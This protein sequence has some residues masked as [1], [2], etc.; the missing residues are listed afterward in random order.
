MNKAK[1]LQTVATALL[2]SLGLTACGSGG[3]S[4]SSNNSAELKRLEGDLQAKQAEI[5]KL[6]E[7]LSNASNNPQRQDIEKKLKQAIEDSKQAEA[8]INRLNDKVTETTKDLGEKQ[9]EIADLNG[10]LSKADAEIAQ[11]EEVEKALNQVKS[12][13][14]TANEKIGEFVEAIKEANKVATTQQKKIDDYEEQIFALEGEVN[15]LTQNQ[16]EAS[17]KIEKLTT[18]ITELKSQQEKAKQAKQDAEAQIQRLDDEK[19]AAINEANLKQTKIDEFTLAL[20]EATAKASQAEKDKA[21]IENTL[22]T[23]HQEKLGL[24]RQVIDLSDQLNSTQIQVDDLTQQ[25]NDLR[26]QAVIN[27]TS[28]ETLKLK[29]IEAESLVSKNQQ[30]IERLAGE[31]KTASDE[32]N[33]LLEEKRQLEQRIETLQQKL[34][35][36]N[37]NHTELNAQLRIAS[38]KLKD[39]L[40]ELNKF[41]KVQFSKTQTKNI[42]IVLKS[43]YKDLSLDQSKRNSVYV[44]GKQVNTKLSLPNSPSISDDEDELELDEPVYIGYMYDDGQSGY[45]LHKPNNGNSAQ[46]V[47]GGIPTL[48]SSFKDIEQK[49]TAIYQG[50][51][52]QITADLAGN[53]VTNVQADLD[54]TYN[55]S[56]TVNFAEKSVTGKVGDVALKAEKIANTSQVRVEKNYIRFDGVATYEGTDPSLS[57]AMGTYEGIFTGTNANGIAGMTDVK[58]NTKL[59]SIGFAGKEVEPPSQ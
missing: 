22:N 57:G 46:V 18:Q 6:R 20:K 38:E 42:P 28:S 30:D 59:L 34:A 24:E 27:E 21:Q 47:Y 7:Q 58:N 40:K 32:K 8:N 41:N 3:G 56:L 1:T 39:T 26:K 9:R 55:L 33:V 31:L 23:V 13:L 36:A 53:K 19:N 2:L 49:G 15:Q 5:E 37:T 17:G 10:K 54:R 50:Q 12:E 35:Q 51:G 11:K 48:A 29:L 16:E 4:S 43:A 44:V 45:E 52:H 14:E 25:V